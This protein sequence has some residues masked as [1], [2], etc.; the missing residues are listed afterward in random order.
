MDHAL[1]PPAPGLPRVRP[2]DAARPLVW[3]RQGWSDFTRASPASLGYG[4]IVAGFGVMLLW[5][6]WQATY[7]VPALIGGFLLVAPCAA[8]V[9]YAMSDQL[10][11]GGPLDTTAACFAW[12]RNTGSIAL[13]GLFLA[14]CLIFWERIAA[15]LFAL[16]YGGEVPDL[17]RLAADVLFSGR[18]L[19]LVAAFIGAGALIAAAV[20]ALSVVSAPL[21]YHR[22]VDV[23]TAMLTSLRCCTC[24][25]GAMLVWAALIACL[26]AL[27]FATLMLGLVIVF[28]W[29]G[30]ASW[31]AYR[32]LVAD[33]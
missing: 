31:H 10:E 7:L 26:T 11:R 5:V 27:G 3:L 18:Y 19:G 23:I 22:P 28:P 30:H 13:F 25:P 16:T 20:F 8:I 6:A 9:L 2:V 29:L 24:N 15:I 17:S 1:R 33:D 21:L 14:L 32:D 12:R 4:G